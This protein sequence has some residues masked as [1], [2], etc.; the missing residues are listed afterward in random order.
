MIEKF[1]S[2][3][4]TFIETKEQFN[5]VS[6]EYILGLF[7][8]NALK[9]DSS[10]PSLAEMTKKSI[11]LLNRDPDGFF[12]MVEGSQIDS[13]C[14]RH[15]TEKV[16]FTMGKFDEAVKEGIDFALKDKKTLVLVTGDHEAGGMVIDGGSIRGKTIDIKWVSR[17]HTGVPTPIFA[18]GPSAS[19]FT[20]VLNNTDLP[21]KIAKLLGIK[22]FPAVIEKSK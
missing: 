9:L 19:L 8:Y 14:H 13:Y 15:D 22:D 11:Q 5:A 6:G 21:R 16:L 7:Q 18:L 12:L 2:K 4:Y 17:F 1:R 3:G 10:E 20:G